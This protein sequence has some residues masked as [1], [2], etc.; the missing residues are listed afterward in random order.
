MPR[1]TVRPN[2]RARVWALIIVL[3]YLIVGTLYA[4]YTPNWQIPDEPA[5]YNYIAQIADDGALPVLEMGDW[6]QAY[7][8]ALDDGGSDNITVVIGRTVRPEG[9]GEGTS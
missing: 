1:E 7:Q 6:Q 8:D 5:H 3:A 2:K 4:V 9:D